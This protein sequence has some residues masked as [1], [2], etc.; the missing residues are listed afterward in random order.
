V[1]LELDDAILLS[2]ED[3][4]ATA[5]TPAAV[6]TFSTVPH[7]LMNSAEPLGPTQTPSSAVSNRLLRGADSVGSR[8][9][10]AR[11]LLAAAA[12]IIVIGGVSVLTRRSNVVSVGSVP[13]AMPE[14]ST[15]VDSSSD[16]TV[17]ATA[18]TVTT[19]TTSVPKTSLSRTLSRGLPASEDV[20][21]MQQRLNDLHFDVGSVDGIF[22]ANTEM[23]VWVYQSLIL[24]LS[25]KDVT[26][27]VTPELWD[28]MQEPLEL[29]VFRPDASPTH[30]EIFL[31]AQAM[32]LYVNKE[33]R[34]ITHVSSG[35][36]QKW[37]DEFKN[38]PAWP[39]ATTTTVPPGQ[40]NPRYCGTSITP[41]GV[42]KVYLKRDGW[43]DIPL[44]RVFNAISFNA[45][46]AIHGYPDVPKN[47]ASH[48]CVR[49]P[50]HIAQYLPDL[51]HRG[52]QIFVWD[53]VKEPEVYGD[54]KPPADERD[55]TDTTVVT[56][57][58]VAA[59]TIAPT[60]VAPTTTTKPTTTTATAITTTIKPTTIA[61]TQPATSAATL[62]TPSSSVAPVASTPNT[63]AAPLSS[64]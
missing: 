8:H 23:A 30:A 24:N 58:T 20:R 34:L 51:L 42:F 63:T 29:P 64:T 7:R 46:I 13:T 36:G 53:G 22:G 28:R 4:I 35:S 11:P 1:T 40:K 12:A 17:D 37:C 32:V 6:P 10:W 47:P 25:G 39:G 33:L 41:G 38:V 26:G 62:P 5:P 59:T 56:T 14:A 9:L 55:P 54:Q 57:T 48:G 15:P 19:A 45:G 21:V 49:V 16:I 3:I 52:D 18:T 43:I 2:I 27:K 31:P 44:G 60:N 61:A 50:M